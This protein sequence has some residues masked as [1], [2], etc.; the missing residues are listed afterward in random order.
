MWEDYWVS[1]TALVYAAKENILTS[2][3]L[4]LAKHTVTKDAELPWTKRSAYVVP[5]A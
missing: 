3:E 5:R 2:S 1:A 4:K